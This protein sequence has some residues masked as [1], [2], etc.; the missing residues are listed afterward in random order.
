MELL[1]GKK[2]SL[3]NRILTLAI[4]FLIILLISLNSCSDGTNDSDSD[5]I[6]PIYSENLTGEKVEPSIDSEELTTEEVEPTTNPKD[7]NYS[8]LYYRDFL[9]DE[10]NGTK[11]GGPTQGSPEFESDEIYTQKWMS[12]DKKISY[13]NRTKYGPYGNGQCFGEYFIDGESQRISIQQ[14]FKCGEKPDSKSGT[15]RVFY[16]FWHT[17]AMREQAIAEGSYYFDKQ[18]EEIVLTVEKV[19]RKVSENEMV[20]NEWEKGY[21]YNDYNVG[22]VIRFREVD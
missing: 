19:D 13:I 1:K 7:R 3:M 15:L 8:E 21:I 16:Q 14:C 9:Q 22:D 2:E 5:I 12:D 20:K 11:F 4:V 6:E 10:E 17:N 18:T